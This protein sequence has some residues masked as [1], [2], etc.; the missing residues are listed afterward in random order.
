M[1]V[2]THFPLRLGLRRGD[3][4]LEQLIGMIGQV[5]ASQRFLCFWRAPK[6]L[7]VPE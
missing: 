5:S 4:W 2:R 6:T 1:A 3:A 7:E